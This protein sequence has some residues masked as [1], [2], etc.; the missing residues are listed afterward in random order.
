MAQ[1]RRGQVADIVEV[2]VV[3]P[4]QERPRLA[5]EDQVLG[6]AHRGA[7]LDPLLDEV[8]GVG[9][10]RTRL[11][12]HIDGEVHD[13]LRNGDTPDEPLEGDDVE[14]IKAKSQAL[15]EAAM[16]LGEEIYKAQQAEAA[17]AE[18]AEGAAGETAKDEKVVDAEFEEVDDDKDQKKKK[19]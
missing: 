12:Y 14:D 15:A 1:H 8:R 18:G 4:V 16:K 10:L 13:R 3:A 2:D 9:S 17:P 19:K 7:V 6:S 5:A 11:A